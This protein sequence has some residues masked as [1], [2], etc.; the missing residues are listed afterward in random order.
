MVSASF[1]T[2]QS[3]RNLE[4]QDRLNDLRRKVKEGKLSRNKAIKLLIEHRKTMLFN[5]MFNR[6][7][8]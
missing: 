3:Q 1:S 5:T 7:F 2:K 4:Y 6:Q 8:K